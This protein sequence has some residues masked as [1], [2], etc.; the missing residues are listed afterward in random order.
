MA[1]S[2]AL[3]WTTRRRSP[4]RITAAR[5][6]FLARLQGE[7]AR[8]GVIDMLRHG[9]KHG[10][11]SFDMF[12]GMPSPENDKAFKRVITALFTDDAQLFKQFQDNDSFR[13]WLTD[14]IFGM[15]YDEPRL[16]A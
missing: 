4:R 15:T 13:H 16:Q 6:K 10:P 11:L 12:Y 3:F 1:C 7:I 14:M 9:I 2:R 8:R 5:Q